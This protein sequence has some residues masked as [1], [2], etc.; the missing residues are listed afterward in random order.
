MVPG[1][2]T[3]LPFGM[4]AIIVLTRRDVRAAFAYPKQTR[5][6]RRLVRVLDVPASGGSLV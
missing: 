2:W 4:W 5:A 6:G 3:A 1:D